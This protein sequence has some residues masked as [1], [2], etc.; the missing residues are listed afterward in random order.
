MFKKHI[1]H[2]FIIPRVSHCIFYVDD[3]SLYQLINHSTNSPTE[4]SNPNQHSQTCEDFSC[5]LG[6]SLLES[7]F[8]CSKVQ[9]L[10]LLTYFRLSS[11]VF[12]C[13]MVLISF[14]FFMTY[15]TNPREDYWKVHFKKITFFDN[16]L[17]LV[18][19]LIDGFGG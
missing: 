11:E 5:P 4:V 13:S 17:M 1:T 12:S 10:F 7:S 9:W 8:L 14:S 19:H 2:Y 6:T 3:F 18:S 15:E 16:T